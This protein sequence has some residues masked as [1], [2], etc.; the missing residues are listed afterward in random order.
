MDCNGGMDYEMDYGVQQRHYFMITQC[1]TLSNSIRP[2]RSLFY[3]SKATTYDK[4]HQLS[5][6]NMHMTF[7][8]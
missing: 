3:C 4:M 6:L 5:L 7:D 8:P 1:S 2:Q